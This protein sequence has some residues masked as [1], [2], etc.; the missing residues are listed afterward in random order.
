MKKALKVFITGADGQLAKAFCEIYPKDK[1]H[2]A[3]KAVLDVTNRRDVV[4]QIMDV[5]PD[6]IF[7]FASMTRGDD[8]SKDPA[9]AYKINVEGTRNVVECAKKLGCQLLFISTNEVFDGKKTSAYTERDRPNPVTVV[10]KTK[11][12]AEQIIRKNIKKHYIVRTSWL[13]S[14]WSDNFL[15]VIYKKAYKTKSVKLVT[16]EVSSPTYSLDLARAMKKLVES[17][18]FGT[19][20]ITNSGTASRFEFGKK[21]FQLCKVNNLTILPVALDE[22]M[23]HSK[24]PK[25]TPLV[26][27]KLD[28]L[29]I[30]MP[31]WKSSLKKFLISQNYKLWK[32]T[33]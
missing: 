23:R 27:V 19:Y 5:D 24:P 14:K 21:M 33:N 6:I 18:K 31:S 25:Y 2:L 20:H 22:F 29:K 1:L 32:K 15:Y 11:Y 26:S 4:R 8:C 12:K 17:Q 10:G 16:D 13:F 9:G 3:G 30:K 7:H 28:K